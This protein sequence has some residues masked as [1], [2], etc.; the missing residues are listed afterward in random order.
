MD[1]QE[2]FFKD[3]IKAIHQAIDAKEDN[4]EKLQQAKLEKVKELNADPSTEEN[5]DR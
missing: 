2:K 3:Q 5:V 4:F 1:S